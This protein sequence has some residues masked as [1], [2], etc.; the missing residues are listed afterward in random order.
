M[1]QDAVIRQ[2]EM[3]DEAVKH[4]SLAFRE[5]HPQ[6]RWPDIPAC[7]TNSFG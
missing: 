6:M 2:L 7:V 1:A 5:T 4:L 3:L